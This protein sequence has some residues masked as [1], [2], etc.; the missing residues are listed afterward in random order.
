MDLDVWKSLDD[1]FDVNKYLYHYTNITKAIKIL[2]SE[3]LIFSPLTTMNDTSEYKARLTVDYSSIRQED[4]EKAGN[5]L[6]KI[7]Q[8]VNEYA[9]N[10]RLLCFSRDIQLN[11]DAPQDVSN[12]QTYERFFDLTGRGCALPRMWAQYASNNEGVCLIFDKSKLLNAV[13]EKTGYL[14]EGE[15]EYKNYFYRY[16]MKFDELSKIYSRMSQESNGILTLADLFKDNDNFVH[17]NYFIKLKDWQNE[18][19]YRILTLV[20][21]DGE[22]A[23]ENLYDY[24][25]GV[26][27]GEKNDPAFT[28]IFK[29]QL[30]EKN[31]A[32]KEIVF[33]TQVC[34][35]KE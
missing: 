15:V 24:L 18:Y 5:M 27:V 35:F 16:S 11:K 9:K 7:T 8:Y 13:R 4:K 31:I 29:S 34:K 26:V 23:I 33:D 12:W 6:D 22:F 25:V 2:F 3:K 30:K 1:K 28:K 17:Y 19:E 14:K 20:N 21:N 10:V 32:V